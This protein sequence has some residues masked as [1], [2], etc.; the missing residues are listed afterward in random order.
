MSNEENCHVCCFAKCAY[1][2]SSILSHIKISNYLKIWYEKLWLECHDIIS[3]DVWPLHN[4]SCRLKRDFFF[5][6]SWR[7]VSKMWC[8]QMM[9]LLWFSRQTNQLYCTHHK[10]W[11][12]YM[13]CLWA[14]NMQPVIGQELCI[15]WAPY[16]FEL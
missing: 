3:F 10:L 14:S 7:A 16:P 5:F 4:Y 6:L 15:I 9:L 13:N 2:H 8:W 11:A 1:L 12:Y